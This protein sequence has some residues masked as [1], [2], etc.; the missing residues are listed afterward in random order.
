VTLLRALAAITV[1]LITFSCC[2]YAFSTLDYGGTPKELWVALG[3]LLAVSL[4]PFIPLPYG[5]TSKMLISFWALF[6]GFFVAALI[7]SDCGI[8][9]GAGVELC[10]LSRDCEWIVKNAR[11]SS[12]GVAKGLASVK[13]LRNV[14]RMTDEGCPG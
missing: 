4:L 10:L 1:F 8:G 7:S 9:S 13:C 11:C 14:F 12:N 3:V 6:A 2:A 5:R